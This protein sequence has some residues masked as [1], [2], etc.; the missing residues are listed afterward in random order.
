MTYPI[1]SSVVLEVPG[2]AM[3]PSLVTAIM[4]SR[5]PKAKEGQR[6]M[7]QEDAMLRLFSS[8]HC[9]LFLIQGC[10][11]HVSIGKWSAKHIPRKPDPLALW[12][13]AQIHP[14]FLAHLQTIQDL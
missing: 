9:C 8:Q 6:C 14:M 10:G 3:E 2:H 5:G 4:G 12:L 7:G 11:N 13:P 1:A